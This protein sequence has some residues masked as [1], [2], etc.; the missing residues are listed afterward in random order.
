ML[1]FDLDTC[2]GARVATKASVALFDREST[3]AAKLDP[4]AARH[5]LDYLVKD[6]GNDTFNVSL[7]QVRILIGN[8]LHQF[9]SYHGY[10]PLNKSDAC[11]G[12]FYLN[13][14]GNRAGK[15]LL[16]ASILA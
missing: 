16:P 9:G 5:G 8:L 7:V 4:V 15:K 2:T 10:P 11:P 3:K 12:D 14:R 13:Y 1:F 6:G